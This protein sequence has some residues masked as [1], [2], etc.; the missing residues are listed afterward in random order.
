MSSFDANLPE[1]LL[2]A[3]LDEE[4]TPEERAQIEA[5]LTADAQWRATLDD[6][7]YAREVTRA[8]PWVEPPAGFVDA[9]LDPPP[10]HR[11]RARL[12]AVAG[13]AAAVVAAVALAVPSGSGHRVQP[14]VATMSDQHGATA[15]QGDD[16]V[17][18]LAPVAVPVS[19]T[20]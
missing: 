9:L 14:Q 20:P 7:R 18:G 15:A 5:R 4:C 11:G 8:L 10:A 17:S 1:D 16:P 2:S 19:F 13:A 12:V 6:V 3:Y